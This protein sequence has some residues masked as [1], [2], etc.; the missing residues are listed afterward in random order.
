MPAFSEYTYQEEVRFVYDPAGGM[1]VELAGEALI[2]KGIAGTA[3]VA[4]TLS[5]ASAISREIAGSA[6]VSRTITGPSLV[7][8]EDIF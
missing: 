8:E 5:G 3:P 7:G 6:L 4:R 2:S 1:E